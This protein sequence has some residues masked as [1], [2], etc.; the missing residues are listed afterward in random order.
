MNRAQ[1][2]NG[3]DV[4]FVPFDGGHTIPPSVESAL[5]T[6]LAAHVH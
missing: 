3:A 2:K 1:E 4:T 6:W 5:A